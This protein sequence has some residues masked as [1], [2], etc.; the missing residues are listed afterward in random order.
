MV[1]H[2][3]FVSTRGRVDP[4]GGERSSPTIGLPHRG[5]RREGSR[6]EETPWGQLEVDKPGGGGSEGAD[7][8]K[9]A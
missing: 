8:Q 1:H 4:N 9:Q 7:S 5:G 3:P 2:R 6:G